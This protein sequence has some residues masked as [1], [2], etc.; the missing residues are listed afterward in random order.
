MRAIGDAA[1]AEIGATGMEREFDLEVELRRFPDERAVQAMRDRIDDVTEPLLYRAAKGDKT[2]VRAL[3]ALC[4]EAVDSLLEALTSEMPRKVPAVEAL[5][6]A[7]AL[8]ASAAD[9]LIAAA[10]DSDPKVR[11]NAVRA[12]GRLP[13]QAVSKV[14]AAVNRALDD[15]DPRVAAAARSVLQQRDSAHGRDAKNRRPL[16]PKRS[17]KQPGAGPSP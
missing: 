14:L 15:A 11:A 13:P 10:R 12:L 5:A 1:L 2:A 7:S 4:P 8:P 16:R 17:A 6:S 3:A 9:P